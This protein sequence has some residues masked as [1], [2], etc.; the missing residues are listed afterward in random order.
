MKNSALVLN[1]K[2]VVSSENLASVCEKIGSKAMEVEFGSRATLDFLKTEGVEL[3]RKAIAEYMIDKFWTAK[4]WPENVRKPGTPA[5]LDVVRMG[6]MEKG[7]VATCKKTGKAQ[8]VTLT[9]QK[10]G[11]GINAIIC[12]N[13]RESD[14]PAPADT[15]DKIIAALAALGPRADAIE[16]EGLSADILALVEKYSK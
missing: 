3:S 11:Q 10:L 14:A 8:A 13:N 2:L 16:I 1:A 12:L 15:K 6:G 5:S 7:E 9:Q 4:I